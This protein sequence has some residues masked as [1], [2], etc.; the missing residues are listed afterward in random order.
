MKSTPTFFLAAFLAAFALT[1]C[2]QPKSAGPAANGPCM[3]MGGGMGGGGMHRCAGAD[4]TY[5]WSM[6]TPQE[7]EEHQKKMFDLKSP[8]ECKAYMDQHHRQMADRARQRG[9]AMPGQPPRD[10]CEGLK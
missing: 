7:R 4:N 1:A 5:G 10:M 3:G 8:G 6:M 2:A 9:S